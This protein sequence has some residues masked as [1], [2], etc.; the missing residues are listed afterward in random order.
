[1]QHWFNNTALFNGK[2]QGVVVQTNKLTLLI[3]QR[4]EIV[5]YGFC[6]QRK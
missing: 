3:R 2:V 4:Q 6:D 5:F 1:M